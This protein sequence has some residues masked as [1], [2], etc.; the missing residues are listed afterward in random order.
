MAEQ[1]AIKA[2]TETLSIILALFGA[3]SPSPIF[4]IELVSL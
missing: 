1:N 4:T 3:P 2:D